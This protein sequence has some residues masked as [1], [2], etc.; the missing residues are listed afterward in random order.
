[1]RRGFV[2]RLDRDRLSLE[3]L[4]HKPDILFVP[5]HIFPYFTP[6]KSYITVHDVAYEKYPIALWRFSK[7]LLGM[8]HSPS[9]MASGR[10]SDQ[11]TESVKS[12]LMKYYKN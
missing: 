8:D 10:E 3:M 2:S 9:P 6:K 11:P 1:M 4:L 5:A 12:D 7:F